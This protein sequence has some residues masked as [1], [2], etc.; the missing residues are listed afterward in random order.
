VAG[1]AESNVVPLPR[2]CDWCDEPIRRRDV[3]VRDGDRIYHAHRGCWHSYLHV[4]TERR[5]PDRWT[6]VVTDHELGTFG[7]ALTRWGAVRKI[8]RRQYRART[9]MY[10]PVKRGW[11][12]QIVAFAVELQRVR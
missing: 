8:N 11:R 7:S 2:R 5:N 9:V 3:S 4:R 1:A 6:V 12:W 10:V